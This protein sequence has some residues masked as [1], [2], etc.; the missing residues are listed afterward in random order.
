MTQP[1]NTKQVYSFDDNTIVV[2]REILQ[3]SILTGKNLVDLLRSVKMEVSAANTLVDLE[4]GTLPVL[5]LT[6]M[7]EWV[8]G[9][10]KVIA[11]L[12]SEIPCEPSDSDVN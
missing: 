12:E 4:D 5:K 2:I 6:P 11:Q 7:R 10:N 3:M 8:E 1:T 9:Y